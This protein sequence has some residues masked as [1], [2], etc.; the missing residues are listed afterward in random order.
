M[1]KEIAERAHSSTTI[2]VTTAQPNR[3]YNQIHIILILAEGEGFKIPHAQFSAQR[4]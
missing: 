2:A 1:P 4:F 3:L